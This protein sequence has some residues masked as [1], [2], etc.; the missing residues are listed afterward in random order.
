MRAVSIGTV[1]F[2]GVAPDAS[3]SGNCF[4]AVEHPIRPSHCVVKLPIPPV[5]GWFKP[6]PSSVTVAVTDYV[7]AWLSAG[8]ETAKLPVAGFAG[9]AIGLG[10]GDGSAVGE[11]AVGEAEPT[12]SIIGTCG[13]PVCAP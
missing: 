11:S 1:P 9:E 8:S 10:S 13:P 4:T 6:Q 5:S 3:R 12:L 2:W 7:V